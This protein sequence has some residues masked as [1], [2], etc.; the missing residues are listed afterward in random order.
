MYL[1]GIWILAIS[2]TATVASEDNHVLQQCLQGPP[3]APGNNGIPGHNGQ[4]VLNGEKGQKGD[5]GEPVKSLRIQV[6]NGNGS[7]FLCRT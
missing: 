2:L 4:N 5:T 3:G 1:S 7:R 6:V